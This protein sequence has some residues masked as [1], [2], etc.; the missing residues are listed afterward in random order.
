VCPS[1][2]DV[3]GSTSA[4]DRKPAVNFEISRVSPHQK[5]YNL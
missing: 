5:D 1:E 3:I 4:P 2:G